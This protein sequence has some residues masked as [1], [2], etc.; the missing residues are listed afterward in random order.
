MSNSSRIE[1]CVSLSNIPGFVTPALLM[2]MCNAPSVS[3]AACAAAA[4]A[5]SRSETSSAVDSALPP[6]A[7]M[8]SAT[9][10]AASLSKSVTSTAAPASASACA[11]AEPIPPAAPV[12]RAERPVKSK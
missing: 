12:T 2:T 5:D 8:R 10:A 4:S 6:L 11:T 3:A 7:E 9:A 1:S